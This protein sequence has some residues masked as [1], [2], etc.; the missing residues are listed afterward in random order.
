MRPKIDIILR[1]VLLLTN[2][3]YLTTERELALD[4]RVTLERAVQ[5]KSGFR[6]L[7]F[8]AKTS[9]DDIFPYFT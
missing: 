1:E 6:A 4:L 3:R 7:I 8:D 9:E 5:H 2:V